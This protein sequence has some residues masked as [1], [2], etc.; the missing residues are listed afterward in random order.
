MRSGLVEI[1]PLR[2]HDN[3]QASH[4]IT[5]SEVKFPVE[6]RTPNEIR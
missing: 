4:L 3:M 5:W 1:K 6:R 2:D